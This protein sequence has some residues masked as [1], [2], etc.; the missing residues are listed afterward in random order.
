MLHALGAT[1]HYDLGTGLPAFPD[2]YA[3][4]NQSPLYPQTQAEIMAGRIPVSETRADIPYGLKD[5]VIG[6]LTAREIGWPR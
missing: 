3:A 4:P 5:T 2:G 6:P 1:D